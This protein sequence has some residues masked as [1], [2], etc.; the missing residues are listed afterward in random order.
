VRPGSVAGALI[1]ISAV[2]FLVVG[3]GYLLVPGSILSTTAT[4]PEVATPFLM[5]TQG[6]ALL[7]MAGLLWAARSFPPRGRRLVLAS[8]AFDY[9]VGSA[10]DLVAFAGGIVGV[11]SV[12]SAVV[13]IPLGL[14]CLGAAL[15][16]DRA[17][18][19]GGAAAAALPSGTTQRTIRDLRAIEAPIL[20]P[21]RS[22]ELRGVG[23]SEETPLSSAEERPA[24]AGGEPPTPTW[25]SNG[26]DGADGPR[27]ETAEEAFT[28]ASAAFLGETADAP[29]DV[30]APD[31]LAAADD[32]TAFLANLASAMKEAATA[33]RTRVSEDVDRRRETHLAGIE[34]RR[35]SEA[36]RIR[37]LADDDRTAIEAWVAS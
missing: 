30:T 31:Q 21:R 15:V 3:L 4:A 36:G 33:E 11:A 14:A 6:V 32:G 22:A 24:D 34:T 8:L 26:A 19:D 12:S 29:S 37:E 27:G 5:R 25:E 23:M 18:S 10:V 7:T 1:S 13:R 28:D 9:V 20:P 35:E 17:T 16:R 2:A